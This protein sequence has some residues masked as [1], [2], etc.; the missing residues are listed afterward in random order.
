[1]KEKS[2]ILTVLYAA[3]GIGLGLIL[4][5]HFPSLDTL[6]W[7]LVALLVWLGFATYLAVTVWRLKRRALLALVCLGFFGGAA[8]LS[9]YT[10]TLSTHAT[11]LGRKVPV[12]NATAI[13]NGPAD[14]EFRG[15]WT[16]LNYWH[17]F[18]GP[19]LEELPALQEFSTNHSDIAVVGLSFFM[20]PEE[21][22]IEEQ[23]RHFRMVLDEAGVSY[24]TFVLKNYREL[25]PFR[26]T[27]IPTTLLIDPAGK[28]AGQAQGADELSLLL[29]QTTQHLQ[30]AG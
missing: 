3:V 7:R 11:P 14:P 28:V 15:R 9:S 24:P 26:F 27:T 23:L 29:H 21:M 25:A 13:I 4:L 17:F 2:T 6:S 20:S 1:M 18:C 19:C 22:T 5:V 12:V 16:L 10:V 8:Y 30:G